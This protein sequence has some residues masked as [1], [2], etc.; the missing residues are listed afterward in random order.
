MSITLR[1]GRRSDAEACGRICYQAFHGIATAHGFPPDFPNVEL[2]MGVLSM[3]LAHPKMYTVV[4]D[5]DGTIVG[6]NVL[7]ERSQIAGIGPITVAPETQNGGVGRALM[8]NVIERAS[9]QGFPGV[10]LVQSAYHTRSL[11]L[12]TKLGFDPREPLACMQGAAL[13]VRLPGYG[14]RR[15]STDDVA[16]CNDLCRRVHG[17]TRDGEL[18]DATGMG[19]ATVVEH[20][21]RITGYATGIAFFAHAV[22][23]TNT[24]VKALIAAAPEFGGLGFLV[25]MRNADLLRWCLERGL[26]TVQP[27]TLMSMGLY[28]EPAGAY[29]PSIA[30]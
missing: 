30:F 2:A 13:G 11:S 10:R 22:G 9:Q 20:G 1:A 24:D 14:V 15:A 26:R 16:T 18:R 21:S 28:N 8:H 19:T 25:P 12:Y 23:E 4:A 3:L 7:D 29:L 27:M 5:R 6:S 17:H